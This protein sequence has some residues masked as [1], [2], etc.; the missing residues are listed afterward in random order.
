ML[1]W[2]CK[3]PFDALAVEKEQT[4]GTIDNDFE[5]VDYHLYCQK[6]GEKLMI[7]HARMIG[8][9]KAFLERG[10]SNEK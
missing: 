7:S 3:H 8:G 1:F 2:K 6:C 10:F 9:V 5:S 4:V